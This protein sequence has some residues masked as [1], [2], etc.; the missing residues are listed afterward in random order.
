MLKP[1]FRTKPKR[2]IGCRLSLLIAE[3]NM[4]ILK[5]VDDSQRFQT[6][7]LFTQHLTAF[8]E[9]FLDDDAAAN[10]GCTRLCHNV[11]QSHQCLTFCQK[12]VDDQHTVPWIKIFFGNLYIKG[13]SSGKR[14]YLGDVQFSVQ[15][16]GFA[17]LCKNNRRIVKMLCYR[18]CNTNS[19]CLDGQNLVDALP[20]KTSAE[21]FS[22][23]VQQAPTF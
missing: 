20:I 12:I 5:V 11:Q 18:Y 16:F 21:L 17:L 1:Q 6:D 19:G 13:G 9:T 8:L 15:I 2:D 14:S 22:D 4:A 10:S 23:F 7:S 3:H